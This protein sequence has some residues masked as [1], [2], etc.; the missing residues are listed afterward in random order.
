MGIAAKY[1]GVEVKLGDKVFVVPPLTFKQLKDAN[2]KE[3]L[4]TM[5]TIGPKAE[6]KQFDALRDVVF[7]CVSRNYPD[8]SID[9]LEDGLTMGNIKP[10]MQA[11]FGVEMVQS[12]EAPAQAVQ[13]A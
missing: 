12:G 3:K 2:I 9:T 10:L 4:A 11:M 13:P 7:A 1:D 6:D 8:L 5:A